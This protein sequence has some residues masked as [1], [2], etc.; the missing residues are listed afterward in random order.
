MYPTVLENI[1]DLGMGQIQQLLSLSKKL[2]TSE[3]Q[4][5]SFSP[6]PFTA[7]L[8]FNENSTRTKYSFAK[9]IINLDY[10]YV[11]INPESSSMKK[12]EDL[13]E[14]LLTLKAQGYGLLIMRTPNSGEFSKFK[15]HSP[16]PIINAGDG[17]NQHPTQ[18]LLDLFTMIELGED[19]KGKT[20]TFIGD[21]AHSRVVNSLAPLLISWG[22]KV[23]FCGPDEFMPDSSKHSEVKRLGQLESAV[24]GSDILYLLRIQSERHQ[25][26]SSDS[27]ITDYATNFQV[28]QV[29][30]KGKRIPIYHPGPANI[31]VEIDH[32]TLKGE[33][34]RGYHQVENSIFMRMALV[35]SYFELGRGQ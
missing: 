24:D 17:S 13:E 6:N 16:L 1:Q 27:F 23:N 29:S 18:A 10:R 25:S 22:A 12:G 3:T 7:A 5:P 11:D 26:R 30:L 35:K 15:K 9:S 2:K 19:P 4:P 34:Y 31:G 14:T 28:N 33:L 8:I 32:Q 21:C 20:V